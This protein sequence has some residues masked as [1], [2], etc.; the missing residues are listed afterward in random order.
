MEFSMT[1]IASGTEEW[2]DFLAKHPDTRYVDA[3][4]IGLNGMALGK[5]EAAA[6]LA[7]IFRSG[8]AFSACAAVL[9]VHGHGSNAFGMGYDDGDPDAVGFPVPGTLVPVP[10]A[11]RPTAQCVID[12]RDHATGEPLWFDPRAILKTIADRLGADGLNPVIACELEFYLTD[13]RRTPEGGITPAPL[14][15]TGAP[16]RSPANLSVEQLEDYADFVR[17]VSDAALA[18][19]IPATTAVAE[20]GLGQFEINL[21][22]VGD[23][24]Q[25]AD[26][27]VLL[28]RII[29]GVARARGHD[30][31]FMAKPYM[32]QPGS[33]LHVHVSMTDESGRNCF[34]APG[35]QAVLESAIAG[36][37]AT[38]P[39]ALAIF[40][41]NFSAFRRYQ[42]GL[43]A[44]L[45][46]T[47]GFN[48]RSAAFRIP[49]GDGP[50]RRVEHRVAGA[51]A[52][53]HLVLAAIL[54]GMHHGVVKKLRPTP[55]A[56]G[57]AHD[58][59]APPLARNFFEALDQLALAPILGT[60]LPARYPLLY[61][62][63]KLGE[64][65]EVFN[66]P[67]AREY[68]FYL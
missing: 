60:Y 53:P 1:T 54:A 34:S 26:H 21:H 18:Q 56:K 4:M 7:R 11:A 31:T 57:S 36:L 3:F 13:A 27:A 17:E 10:W 48:N 55:E 65:G 44:P 15:R 52:N 63:L 45:N 39:E 46:G 24:V 2:R 62:E 5:R 28:K 12:M 64:F 19:G 35:G 22:H 37:Q 43:F 38:L 32:D 42:P 58:G 51:D 59:E 23:P 68:D 40:A 47:W 25:A 30:A 16:P 9:D 20:Y 8:V 33:G 41:P 50:A 49:I 6:D 66:A 61:R 29:R 67:S 14:K